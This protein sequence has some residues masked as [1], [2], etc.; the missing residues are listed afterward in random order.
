MVSVSKKV[1][2]KAVERNRIRRIIKEAIKNTQLQKK[3]VKFIVRVNIHDLKMQE[4]K[5]II[6][7]LL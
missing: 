4:V 2:A 7:N 5:S 6:N 3:A 1:A